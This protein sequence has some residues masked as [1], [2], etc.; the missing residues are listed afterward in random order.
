MKTENSALEKAK[1]LFMAA[2]S[3]MQ[4]GDVESAVE[5]FKKALELA[6][7]HLGIMVA[8]GAAHVALEQ[9]QEAQGYCEAVLDEGLG[10]AEGWNLLG[11]INQ[12]LGRPREGLACFEKALGLKPDFTDAALNLGRA[13]Y[14]LKHPKHALDLAESIVMSGEMAQ[15]AMQLQ[16]EA[17][18]ALNREEEAFQVYNASISMRP[19]PAALGDR[20]HIFI[21]QQRYGEALADLEQSLALAPRHFVSLYNMASLLKDTGHFRSGLAFAE[22]AVAV[23]PGDADARYLRSVLNLITGDF[24]GGWADFDAR[25]NIPESPVVRRINN[26]YVWNF[27][28]CDRL[29][30]WGEQGI[31]EEVLFSTCLNNVLSLAKSVVLVVNPK[32]KSLLQ[33]AFPGTEVLGYLEFDG[34]LYTH[35]IPMGDLAKRFRPSLSS[36]SMHP[37]STLRA[38][39]IRVSA[40][41]AEL[42]KYSK[43]R[44][45]VGFTWFSGRDEFSRFKSIPL[46]ALSPLLEMPDLQFVNLQYGPQA[47]EADGIPVGPGSDLI[48]LQSVDAYDDLEGLAALIETCDV[49]VSVSNTTA[50]LA[51]ALCKPLLLL[52][53]LGPG[54]FWYWHCGALDQPVPW[55]TDVRRFVQRTP[56]DWTPVVADVVAALQSLSRGEG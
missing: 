9:F 51:A 6:P 33:R 25:F 14:R 54:H 49:V 44:L 34:L 47:L 21:K 17:L 41:S 45:R 2:S 19:T 13:L 12:K 39:P 15:E 18:T 50:H 26:P 24:E 29:V 55:Y 1:S 32:I 37:V 35:H 8:L 27:E 43:P 30:V 38:D 20:A 28:A 42:A 36:F 31:G 3:S 23:S 11:V 40:V 5:D 53:P 22:Q 7:G 46:S 16:A 10:V 56:G 4:R 52:L 48:R